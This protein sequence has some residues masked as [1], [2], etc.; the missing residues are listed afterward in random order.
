MKW[1][2]FPTCFYYWRFMLL[3]VHVM[4]LRRLEMEDH[5]QWECV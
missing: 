4:S 1:D 5:R 3:M 2:E